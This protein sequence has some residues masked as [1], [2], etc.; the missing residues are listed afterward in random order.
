M[1]TKK[2]LLYNDH[3]GWYSIQLI[4][5]ITMIWLD[6]FIENQFEVRIASRLY[7]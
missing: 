1:N 2:N 3:D 6:S 5:S 4:V 7:Q